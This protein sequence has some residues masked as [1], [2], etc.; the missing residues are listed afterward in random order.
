MATPQISVGVALNYPGT[1]PTHDGG[2]SHIQIV[3]GIDHAKG[4]VCLVPVCSVKPGSDPTCELDQNSPVLGLK[5]KSYIGHYAAKKVG[6]KSIVARIESQEVTFIGS[7][8]KATYDAI[9]AG[10][11]SSSETEPWFATA[12]ANCN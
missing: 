12:V 6:L 10:I 1:G 3:V 5:R 8:Q 7:L 4:D 11:G 2:R 9:L